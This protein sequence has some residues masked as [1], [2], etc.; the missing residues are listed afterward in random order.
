M[1]FC[2]DLK[3]LG[4]FFLRHPFCSEVLPNFLEARTALPTRRLY[5]PRG[6]SGNGMKP[7]PQIVSE[8]NWQYTL[9][10]GATLGPNSGLKID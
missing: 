5:R 2:P 1:F 10:F 9:F 8:S 4:V 7:S 3:K 6:P